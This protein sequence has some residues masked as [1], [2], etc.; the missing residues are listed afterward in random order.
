MIIK[1][2]EEL[3]KAKENNIKEFV[4]VGELA[5]KLNKASKVSKLSKRAAIILAGV[6]GAGVVTAPFTG[7]ASLGITGAGTAAT[8]TTTGVSSGVIYAALA[9]GGLLTVYALYKDYN[10]KLVGNKDGSIELIFNK[11]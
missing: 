6:I 3:K 8:A 2:K 9:A 10:V 1:T 7:G 5:E 4:V 11:K